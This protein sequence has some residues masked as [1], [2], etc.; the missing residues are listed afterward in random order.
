LTVEVNPDLGRQVFE[1]RSD[2]IPVMEVRA[3]RTPSFDEDDAIPARKR[4]AEEDAPTSSPKRRRVEP[5][6]PRHSSSRYPYKGPGPTSYKDAM[7][8]HRYENRDRRHFGGSPVSYNDF[9]DEQNR[10]VQVLPMSGPSHED[11]ECQCRWYKTSSH[12][13]LHEKMDGEH[14]L[15]IVKDNLPRDVI[16]G[17]TSLEVTYQITKPG[18]RLTSYVQAATIIV[19][20]LTQEGWALLDRVRAYRYE[21]REDSKQRRH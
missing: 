7:Q 5:S 13:S 18:D 19:R 15:I 4:K 11:F 1:A 21:R 17:Q 20:P 12:A 8:P 3:P 9:A 10:V 16:D 2:D 6:P 14:T